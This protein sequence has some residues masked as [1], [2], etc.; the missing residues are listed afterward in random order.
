MTKCS[1]TPQTGSLLALDW[2]KRSVEPQLAQCRSHAD[3]VVYVHAK[4]SERG[5]VVVA[6]A[7]T[8]ATVVVLAVAVVVSETVADDAF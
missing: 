6:A 8:A 7:A 1:G 5:V 3:Y 2:Q 4:T